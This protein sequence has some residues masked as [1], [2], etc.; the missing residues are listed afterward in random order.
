VLELPVTTVMRGSASGSGS[1]TSS[2][3]SSGAASG[4]PASTVRKV[5]NFVAFQCGWLACVVGAAN[6]YAWQG[7]IAA[8]LIVAAHVVTAARPAVEARLVA[9]ALLL[10]VIWEWSLLATGVL[11][12]AAGAGVAGLPPLW[13]LALWPLFASTLN[14]SLAW[15]QGRWLLAAILGAVSGPAAYWAG[16]RLG[17][18]SFT[19]PLVFVAALA[20]GWAIL[21]PALLAIAARLAAAPRVERS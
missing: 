17:A 2:G 3:D 8:V 14:T 7:V 13:I 10:G 20:V 6:G 4:T 1:G 11:G 15:L 12:Y 21:T 19:D 18:L 9:L 5:V 16:A